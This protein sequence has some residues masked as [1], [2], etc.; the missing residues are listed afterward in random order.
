MPFNGGPCMPTTLI[1]LIILVS[2]NAF[3]AA[4][5]F[6][7][8]ELNQLKTK[9]MADEGNQKAK[10][11]HKLI[12]EPSRFL[13]TIQI[14]ITLTG[15]LASAFAADH[16]SDQFANFLM[17]IGIPLPIEVLD[18]ISVMMITAILSYFTLVFGELVPK[19]I[20]LQ[21]PE[22]IANFVVFPLTF[23]FYL[24]Y[25]LVKLLTFSTNAV[26]R[27]FGINP[28]LSRDEATE[29][30]I[31]MMVEMGDI[32]GTINKSESEMIQNVFEFNDK[33]V[34]DIFTHRVDIVGISVEASIQEALDFVNQNRYT[35]YPVFD[36]DIDNIVGILHVKDLIYCIQHPKEPFQLNEIIRKPHFVMDSIRVDILFQLM[37]KD[38]IHI[39]IVIDEYGGTAGIVTIEDVIEE[40]V[41]EIHSETHNEEEEIQKISP[42][43]YIIKGIT[44][45][46]KIEDELNIELPTKEFDTLNGF[47]LDQLGHY[48]I[49]HQTKVIEYGKLKFQIIEMDQKRIQN[50]ILTI[51]E[52]NEEEK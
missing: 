19:K 8:V 2:L 27:L 49:N 28:H 48:P 52:E 6:A 42:N 36:G 9:R 31:R 4:S 13:S 23:I 50:V 12:S 39:A 40:I 25:P 7:L 33:L 26:V 29:E 18:T 5:E 46:Y 24:C 20:A 43:Q 38:N 21:M 41:G 34:T 22:R 35:R 37:Q 10:L 45:L 44:H 30:E 47:L 32:Q 16:F 11:L 15:F 14:G 51:M 17:E 1:I 3:F